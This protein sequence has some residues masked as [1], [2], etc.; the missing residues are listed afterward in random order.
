M[1][2]RDVLYMT[3]TRDITKRAKAES[4]TAAE[5]TVAVTRGERWCTI[6][7]QWESEADF[8]PTHPSYCR[9]GGNERNALNRRRHIG[10]AEPCEIASQPRTVVSQVVTC[11]SY[12]KRD[13]RGYAAKMADSIRFEKRPL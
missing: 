13:G 6:H 10:P 5:R 2:L 1:Q 7:Q 3:T 11:G 8:S 12:E 4:P 9:R